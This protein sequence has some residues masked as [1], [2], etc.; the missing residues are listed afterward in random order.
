M[1]LA[2]GI[3]RGRQPIIKEHRQAKFEE[4]FDMFMNGQVS[5]NYVAERAK[6]V[7]EIGGNRVSKR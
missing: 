6:K 4:A 3:K 5:A 7:K 2:K 1:S